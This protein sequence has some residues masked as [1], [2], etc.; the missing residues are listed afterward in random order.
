[1]I[2]SNVLGKHFCQGGVYQGHFHYIN[3]LR[4]LS[5]CQPLAWG[6]S[7]FSN[8][9][10]FAYWQTRVPALSDTLLHPDELIFFPHHRSI[11]FCIYFFIES[12]HPIDGKYL[13]K[14]LQCN[15][16]Y[17]LQCGIHGRASWT[18]HPKEK[19]TLS[20]LT[21][22]SECEYVRDMTDPQPGLTNPSLRLTTTS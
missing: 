16:L 13:Y 12:L 8:E 3:L 17:P 7:P 19:G 5:L 14:S 4:G 21:W 9:Q 10:G 11:F 20:S 6:L 15:F 22:S 2:A 1:M 18:I